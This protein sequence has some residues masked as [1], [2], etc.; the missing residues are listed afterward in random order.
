MRLSSLLYFLS[1]NDRMQSIQAAAH[2][3]ANMARHLA[4]VLLTLQD[5]RWLKQALLNSND[6]SRYTNCIYGQRSTG[7]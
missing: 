3:I 2:A 6:K 5:P 4:F 7:A 1:A